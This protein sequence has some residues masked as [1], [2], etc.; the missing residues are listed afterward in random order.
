MPRDFKTVLCP[1]DFSDA[2][3]H[4]LEYGLRFAQGADGLLIVAHVIHVPGGDLLTGQ[5]FSLNFKEAQE[6]VL[7]RL[8]EVHATRL[9]NY[10]KCELVPV[11]GEPAV[12]ISAL[13]KSRAA[14]LIIMSTHGRSGLSHL[15]MGSVAEQIL[16]HA[17]C[18][19]FIVR[20]GVE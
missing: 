7:D 13:A 17:P 16:R 6:Q 15:V 10:A 8:R 1:T 2:S 5:S 18:P 12:E 11:I 4:A 19:V 20:A 14:D 3:Y 9:R